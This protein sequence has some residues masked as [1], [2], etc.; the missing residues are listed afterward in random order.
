MISAERFYIVM[1]V[2]LGLIFVAS[3][4][5]APRFIPDKRARNLLIVALVLLI[6]SGGAL[7]FCQKIFRL[8]ELA[9]MGDSSGATEGAMETIDRI[10]MLV[11]ISNLFELVAIGLC[12]FVGKRLIF[13][14][15]EG[16]PE[17][18]TGE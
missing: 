7:A 2:V 17:G 13:L 3:I 10:R 14:R 12:V 16:Q 15:S 9:Y 8:Y 11:P 1:N 5:L 4:I 18:G 6:L